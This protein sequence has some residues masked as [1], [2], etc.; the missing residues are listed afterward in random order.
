MNAAAAAAAVLAATN[1]LITGDNLT[2]IYK[3][4]SRVVTTNNTAAATNSVTYLPVVSNNERLVGFGNGV[5]SGTLTEVNQILNKFESRSTNSSSPAP[6]NSSSSMNSSASRGKKVAANVAAN[7]SIGNNKIS[8][9]NGSIN[10]GYKF[11]N[12]L[13]WC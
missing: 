7:S 10:K 8:S 11:L 3:S 13:K 2:D 1:N 9:K 12:Y 6:N 4:L 5:V